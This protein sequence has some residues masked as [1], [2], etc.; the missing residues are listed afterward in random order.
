MKVY[1]VTAYCRHTDKYKGI[2]VCS[3]EEAAKK[4]V[5]KQLDIEYN[6]ANF[7]FGVNEYEVYGEK[8]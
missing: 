3:T 7:Y 8:I 4:Y 1:I 6:R 2:T 5:N